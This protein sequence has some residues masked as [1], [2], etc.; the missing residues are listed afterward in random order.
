[1][2]W[3]RQQLFDHLDKLSIAHTT[4]EHPPLFT[5]EESQALRGEIPGA[6]TKNLFLKCKKGSIWLITAL[7]MTAVDLKTLHKTLE[8]GRLSFGNSDLLMEL[9]GI[10]PG[11]VSAFAAINDRDQRVNVVL[12]RALQDHDPVNL[13]PLENTATTSIT[14]ADLIRFLDDCGH[15]PRILDLSG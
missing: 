5:V 15:P 10:R 2:P 1:M 9:L 7:E 11:A 8:C 13:H 12:D 14:N 6:H 3:T 4:I